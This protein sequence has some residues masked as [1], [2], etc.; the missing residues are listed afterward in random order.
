[1]SI[2]TDKILEALGKVIDPDL[3]KD[4]VTLGMIRDLQVEGKKVSFSLVLTTPACPLKDSLKNGCISAIK[5]LVDSSAEIDVNLT[6]RVTGSR[7]KNE[8]ILPGV[9]N[10]VAV[11]S[12]KGGVGKSTVAANLAISLART[13]ANVGLLDADI[14]GP[15]IPIMFEAQGIELSAV[16]VGE[17]RLQA[18][19]HKKYGVAM[20]SIGF[21]VDASR[22]LVWRGPMAA[23]FLKQMVTDVQWG[24]LDYMLI[25]LPPGTGDIHLT[26][27]Q[28][29]PLTGAII[30]TTPQ[31]IATADARK[32][33][34]MFLNS[35]INVPVLGIVENMSW[36]TPAEL[37][38][39]KYYL[40]GKDGGM[41]LANETGVP[42]L[43]RIPIIQSV[44]EGGDNGRPE[45][46]NGN[47]LSKQYFDGL[48][49]ELARQISILNAKTHTLSVKETG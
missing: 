25:D 30:V 4:L 12:G 9:K 31:Q 33:I 44:M 21:F 10:I 3:K 35:N 37:P 39:N 26:M 49:S 32:G 24:E 34:D 28:T 38:E 42:F 13:G 1:V 40:F 20:V 22:A 23:N 19:P 47:S 41:R 46:I 48:A 29:I 16:K 8:P 45:T 7:P 43:G 36:F 5:Q 17:G 18:I 14:Y 11:S 15:S 6:S 27:V 2:T